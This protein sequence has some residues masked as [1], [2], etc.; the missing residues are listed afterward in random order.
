MFT[1]YV[2][3]CVCVP[4]ML[5]CMYTDCFVCCVCVQFVL[6]F[7]VCILFVLFPRLYRLTMHVIIMIMD[8]SKIILVNCGIILIMDGCFQDYSCLVCDHDYG[9]FQDYTG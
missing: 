6:F 4:S 1:V 9:C 7:L 5:L 3:C 2:V 8:A